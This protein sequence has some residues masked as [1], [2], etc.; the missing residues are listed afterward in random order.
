MQVSAACHAEGKAAVQIRVL[1]ASVCCVTWC[2]AERK[3]ALQIRVLDASVCC[4]SSPTGPSLSWSLKDKSTTK[5]CTGQQT[6]LSRPAR[7]LTQPA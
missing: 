7:H 1:D 3:A 4:V 5:R 2:H 6:E